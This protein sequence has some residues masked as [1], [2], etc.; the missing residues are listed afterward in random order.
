MIGRIELRL[1]GA[2]SIFG[3]AIGLCFGLACGSTTKAIGKAALADA[4]DCTSTDRA[5]LEAQFGPVVEQALQRAMG[6]D[7][8]IDVPSLQQITGHLEADGWCVVET[9]AAKLISWVAGKVGTASAAA[10]LDGPDLAAQVA[11]IRVEKFGATQFQL[12]PAL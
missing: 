4:V 8:K 5:R 9:E 1:V 11:R 3:L 12:G 2:V 6:M 10:P 7:G